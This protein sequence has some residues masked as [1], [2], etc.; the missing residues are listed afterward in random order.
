MPPTGLL[1][2]ERVWLFD[3]D[4]TLH[5]ASLA[6]FD[7]LDASM[8]AYI[9]Q[10]LGVSHEQADGLRMAYW[11]RYGATLLGLERHHG[12]RATHFLE[13][14][15]RL[16]GLEAALRMAAHDR[17][18]LQ[19]LPGRKMVLTNAPAA[20]AKR[21]LTTLGLSTCFE[22]VVSIEGM[23]VFGQWRPKPDARMLRVVLARL[24]LQPA[25]AVLV[26]DTVGHLRA[27]RRVGL[28]TVWMQ[29][30]MRGRDKSRGIGHGPEAGI[31]LRRK[32]AF[33]CARI[34]SIHELRRWTPPT[35]PRD[36]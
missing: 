36:R 12:I 2:R 16:P 25:R 4:N 27:A 7:R 15:H 13:H 9:A 31:A 14:T 24:K 20:Y 18:A 3:L 28:G 30:Y 32:P 10:H 19:R 17:V 6:V 1:R 26:E 33:V 21:V 29:R 5:D 34:K 23:R 11:R 8:T 22:S 35:T